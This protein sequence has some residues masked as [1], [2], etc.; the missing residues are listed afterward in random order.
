MKYKEWK[1]EQG[2]YGHS[3]IIRTVE[4]DVEF[5]GLDD[6]ISN[7]NQFL[8]INWDT[9]EISSGLFVP[10]DGSDEFDPGDLFDPKEINWHNVD[11]LL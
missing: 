1:K 11:I 8:R 4:T 5:I 9:D 6:T 3:G 7:G 10:Q 2:L